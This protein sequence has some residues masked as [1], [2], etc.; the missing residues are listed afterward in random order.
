MDCISYLKIIWVF[1]RVCTI[2][3]ANCYT[4]FCMLCL[5]INHRTLP[6]A[7]TLLRGDHLNVK[8]ICLLSLHFPSGVSAETLMK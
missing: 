5:S 7:K 8:G 1:F 6:L 4:M 3:S 2:V